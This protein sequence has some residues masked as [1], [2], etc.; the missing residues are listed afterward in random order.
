MLAFAPDLT[1]LSGVASA[2]AMSTAVEASAC[3]V[4]LNVVLICRLLILVLPRLLA[5]L[6]GMI[7]TPS[8]MVAL[9]EETSSDKRTLKERLEVVKKKPPLV[10]KLCSELSNV[11]ISREEEEEGIG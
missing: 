5:L 6:L 9:E 1:E 10:P 7:G 3:T 4:L 2:K 8:V 11:L